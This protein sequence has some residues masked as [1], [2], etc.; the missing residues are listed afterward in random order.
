MKESIFFK[1]DNK[2][3][4]AT[5]GLSIENVTD[6]KHESVSIETVFHREDTVYGIVLFSTNEEWPIKTFDV[7]ILEET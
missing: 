3:Y 5:Q 4:Q 1:K 2:I 7:E 6:R